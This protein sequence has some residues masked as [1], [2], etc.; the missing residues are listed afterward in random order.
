MGVFLIDCLQPDDV[1]T[2]QPLAEASGIAA[3]IGVNLDGDALTE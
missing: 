3:Q 2:V 1:L